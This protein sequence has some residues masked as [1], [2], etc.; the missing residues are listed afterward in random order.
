MILKR[1]KIQHKEKSVKKNYV[2]NV[3]YELLTILMPLIVTPYLSRVLGA[4]G[5]GIISYTESI[6]SYFTMVAAMGIMRYGQREISYI[7]NSLEARSIVFWNTKVLEF[8]TAAI[9][10]CVYLLFMLTQSNKLLYG[11]MSLNILGVFFDITWFFQGLEEF[12]KI[13]S[14]N[15][16]FKVINIAYVFGEVKSRDDMIVY[17]FG[18]AFFTMLSSLSM[19]WHLPGYV[20]S[21]NKEK[22][23]PFKDIK[24]VLSLFIPTIAIQ[25]YTVL[26]KTMIGIILH[27]PVENGYYEQ[28]I[29]IAKTALT[30]VTSLGTVMVP[31]IGF[32][33]QNRKENSV[34][35]LM[36]ESYR[37]VWF[38]G[39]PLCIG[40]IML[41]DLLVPWFL[42]SGFNKVGDLLKILALLIL[43]IGIN[44]VTGVQYL[45]PTK[46]QNIFTLTVLAG[47][48]SNFIM[49]LLLIPI[50]GSIGAAIASVVAET[51]IAV[52]QLIIVRKEISPMNVLIKGVHY[53]VAAGVMGS[54][55]FTLVRS[56]PVS[57]A[58]TFIAV[59]VGGSVYI[60]VLFIEKDEFLF[61]NMSG[62]INKVKR[63]I[64]AK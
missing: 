42:G 52:I 55:L 49:N 28:G 16:I 53:F 36:Y 31:R 47:A 51:L 6:V 64:R 35:E 62:A 21:I 44:N 59:F 30:L 34:Q 3:C 40:M 46:R 4:E 39:L 41:S 19:W 45:I 11:V 56:L 25:V 18:L 2:Y 33:F 60:L 58:N 54:V 43:A 29:K 22:L 63:K 14:R 57:I 8:I 50:W 24:V 20:C 10:M 9:T 38:L 1:E 12:G 17:A 13:I 27:N 7:R 5:I 26:D 48:A 37:F 15:I 61:M 32:Y 23:H